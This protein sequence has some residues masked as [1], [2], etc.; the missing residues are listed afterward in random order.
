MRNFRLHS[1]F[2]FASLLFLFFRIFTSDPWTASVLTNDT[3]SYVVTAELPIL[4][5]E[6]ISGPRSITLPLLYKAFTPIPGYD[7][8]IRS[9]PSI[10]KLPGLRDLPGFRN[11]AFVQSVLSVFSWWLLAFALY[12]RLNNR[13]LRYIS[14]S[15][16][17]LS[18]CLPEIVSWDHVMMAESLT[19]SLFAL[20]LALS[21]YLFDLDIFSGVPS[22]QRKI[23]IAA[24][25]LITLFFWV[26][27]R[28]TNAYF[29]SVCILCL[30]TGLVVP[31]I[32]RR[33]HQ[34]PWLGIIIL[35]AACGIY[36][37]QQSSARA[38][39]RLINPLI[40][41]LTANV[42]P[43]T[44]RVQFMHDKWGMPDSVDIISNTSSANYSDIK[45][46]QAF[47]DWVQQ[48]GLSAYS[49]FMIHTPLWTTQILI[50]SVSE[51]FGYYKQPYYD[52]WSLQ[53][54]VRLNQL[55]RMINWSS[56]DLIF[57]SLF[58][59]LAAL[60]KNIRQPK[61]TM[62]PIIGLM[63][64]LWMGAGLMYSASYL[65][66]T[67]GSASRHIQNVILTYR[68]LIFV[69]LPIQFDDR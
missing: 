35:V 39:I 31:L 8:S 18:A 16:I 58:L 37:F 26:N 43:Y 34:I 7:T 46:N 23:A 32:R 2:I 22:S 60:A 66:E 54:P 20:L 21:L 48:K 61:N 63:I 44:T 55:T 6:F 41:N 27:V 25:F 33:F 45:K 11:V 17:L 19:Y 3:D 56:S 5:S 53:L 51:N 68:L 36:G 50:D 67:W 62:W 29:L 57:L 28:D 38:S 65:G 40:N 49:D 13:W 64:C 47:V 15:L 12:R 30:I 10:G 14:I 1:F 24:A 52:P 42:F 59:T 69:F 4:S 9:E